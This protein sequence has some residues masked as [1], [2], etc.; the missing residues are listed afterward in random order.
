MTEPV[1]SP[2]TPSADRGT[3][4]AVDQR[5]S[6]ATLP[7]VT[8]GRVPVYD[9]RSVPRIAHIGVGAF[10]RAHLGVYADDLLQAGWPA[11]IRGVSLR[12]TRAEEQLSPQDGL[13]ALAE[14]EP[15]QERPLRVVGSLKSV[16]T[17]AD[18]ALDAMSS[19]DTMLVTLTVTEKGYE[20]DARDLSE[21]DQPRSVPALITA[22]L[23]RRRG[24]S[25]PPV[26]ASLDNL[27]DNGTLLRDKVLEVAEGTDPE[28]ARWIATEVRFPSSVVD[29]MVPATTADDL[30]DIARRLGLLDLAPVTAEHHCSWVISEAEGLPPLGDVG[31]EVVRDIGAFQR[32]K[33]WL[34]NGPHSALAYCGLL[35]G[36]DSIAAAS[37]HPAVSAFV[38]RLVADILEVA[39]LP[40]AATPQAFAADALRRFQNPSL[41]HTCRQV[42]A[43]GS[44]KLP[45]RLLPVVARRAEGARATGH[46]AVVVAAWLAAVAGIPVPGVALPD[47]DDPAAAALRRSGAG[48]DLRAL[49]YDALQAHAGSRFASEVAAALEQLT[50]RGVDVL[51][52]VP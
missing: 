46:F 43:D 19:P 26:V 2:R 51:L 47:L 16:R 12:S 45:Q 5:L 15:G 32:R 20:L 39:D 28:L 52:E 42:G 41:G 18:A 29:R 6:T 21:P 7:R 11:M 36:C 35:A 31:V 30:D 10:A 34:L 8:A 48:G 40:A 14:R 3:I 49:S 27:L 22:A 13:Y 50:R 9:R 44:R 24:R 17:G 38:R 4:G 23:A 25:A 1:Q 33:L 37:D